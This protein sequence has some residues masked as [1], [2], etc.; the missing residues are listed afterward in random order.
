MKALR[1]IHFGDAPLLA[2]NCRTVGLSAVF[3]FEFCG[4]D[5]GLWVGGNLLQGRGGTGA[6]NCE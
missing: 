2:V 5:T 4:G 6:G 3:K 1:N